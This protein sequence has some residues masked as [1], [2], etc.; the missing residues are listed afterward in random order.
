MAA[1]ANPSERVKSERASRI[2]ASEGRG[3]EGIRLDMTM[4]SVYLAIVPR[5]DSM[6]KQPTIRLFRVRAYSVPA[7]EEAARPD[8]RQHRR[9]ARHS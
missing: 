4:G 1:T 8:G 6:D 3:G 2:S 7:R 9:P 5:R